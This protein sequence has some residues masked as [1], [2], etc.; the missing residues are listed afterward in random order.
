GFGASVAA[1]S[2]SLQGTRSELTASDGAY[3]LNDL[4]VGTYSLLFVFD[5]A[6]LR[7]EN[8]EVTVGSLTVVNAVL[9]TETVEMITVTERA[10]IVDSGSTKQGTHID[11]HYLDNVPLRG[12]TVSG[13]L[14]AAAGSQ[15]DP[16]GVSF[17]GS[18]SVENRY[19][20]DGLDTTGVALGQFSPTQ[21][22]QVL[23]NFIR[24]IESITGDHDPEVV[25][26]PGGVVNVVTK[27]GSNDFHGSLFGNVNALNA[28]LEPNAV[29]GSALRSAPDP[30]QTLDFGV[31]LG[32]PILKD[33][34][35]FYGGFPPLP[36]TPGF[37][38][39][40]STPVAP[41]INR[42]HF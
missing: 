15:G 12:R 24:E 18:G 17:S 10:P 35:W 19:V 34:I 4:P 7:R 22:S 2:P 41:Q 30:T 33:R 1:S 39:H 14:G 25:G 16:Y 11:T 26:P 27:S 9:N 42:F 32:G 40:R 36:P 29:A 13:V 21:G 5:K 38:P 20:L 6:K 28:G 23:N 8:I 31:E 3:R 37:P